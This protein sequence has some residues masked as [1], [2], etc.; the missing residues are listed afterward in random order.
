[1]K[2]GYF[3]YKPSFKFLPLLLPP[4]DI[5]RNFFRNWSR[6]GL[7]GGDGAARFV[8]EEIPGV[9]STEYCLDSIDCCLG[10]W[11]LKCKQIAADYH[12]QW[13]LVFAIFDDFFKVEK[14]NHQ[15]YGKKLWKNEE[16]PCSI[17]GQFISRNDFRY[18]KTWF[19][20]Y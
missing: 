13:N 17:C 1:M 20:N 4:P 6:V 15:L 3:V 9:D 2:F 8:V 5:R 7:N 11:V 19:A 10:E 18:P 14:N 16:K 12:I